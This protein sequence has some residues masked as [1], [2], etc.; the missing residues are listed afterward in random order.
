MYM[1]SL[2]KCMYCYNVAINSD[3]SIMSELSSVSEP[4]SRI[5][6]LSSVS[7]PRSSLIQF[8]LT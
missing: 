6:E 7:E 4:W 2:L 8:S 1:Y 5:K 3:Q